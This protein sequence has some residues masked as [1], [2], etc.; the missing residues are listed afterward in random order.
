MAAWITSKVRAGDGVTSYYVRWRAGGERDGK[1]EVETFSKFSSAVN[2]RNAE[3]FKASVDLAGQQWPAG[4]VKGVGP[5]RPETVEPV[6]PVPVRTFE[7]VGLDHVE[8]RL[9]ITP[10]QRKRYKQQIRTLKSTGFE[11]A[12]GQV[13]FPFDQPIAAITHDDIVLWRRH[14]DQALKTQKNYHGLISGIFSF[15][16]QR[17]LITEHPARG[18]APSNAKVKQQQGEMRFL[19]EAEF[20]TATELAGDD[21]DFLTL[22]ALTGARFGEAT[23]LWTS[24]VNLDK[25]TI[26]INKSWKPEGED[27]E[28][29]IPPWLKKLLKAKHR[30][31]GHYLGAPKTPNATRTI[32]ISQQLVEILRP[33]VEGRAADDFLFTSPTGLPIHNGDYT[34]AVWLPLMGKVVAAGIAPFRKHDLRHSHVA[35]L[36]AAGVGLPNIQW[37][38]GHADYKITVNTYGHLLPQTNEHIDE[39]MDAVLGGRQ[40]RNPKHLRIV[41]DGPTETVEVSDTSKREASNA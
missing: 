21:A 5:V 30:M 23:A 9:D 8:S 31:R 34:D 18:T 19:S 16:L 13:Y 17:G 22:L 35:W 1:R 7:Q 26:T 25:R 2:R 11:A 15:A 38:L 24:D 4:W 39:A 20:Q 14:S 6:P 27:H 28:Q 36:L 40:V 12:G 37:R 10:G 33:Y 3:Q 29:E 32:G 41:R